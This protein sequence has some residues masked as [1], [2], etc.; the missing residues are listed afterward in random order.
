MKNLVLG[1]HVFVVAGR[2]NTVLGIGHVLPGDDGENAGQG[3]GFA[4]SIRLID[5]GRSAS[6]GSCHG[7]CAAA[8]YRRCRAPDRLPCQPRPGGGFERRY[9]GVARIFGQRLALC[10]GAVVTVVLAPV[11]RAN[12]AGVAGAAA[13]IAGQAVLDFLDAGPWVPVQ[14]RDRR[15]DHSRRA[16]SAL[17]G[18]LVDKGFLDGRELAVFRHAFDGRDLLALHFIGENQT[19]VHRLAVH[20]HR[21]G[22]AIAQVAS[23]LG[24]GKAQRVAQHVEQRLPPVIAT[25]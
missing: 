12:N 25:A 24:T 10:A 2:R 14:E 5:H 13:Q 3:H 7:P 9:A 11:H 15:H 8:K 1:K 23:L 6:P 18:A 19:T 4:V 22:A 17:D 20:Q 21:A 16:V